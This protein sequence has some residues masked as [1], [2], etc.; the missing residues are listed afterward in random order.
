APGEC[1]VIPETI[2]YAGGNGGACH[3]QMYI[4]GTV[5]RHGSAA[6]KRQYLPKIAT[7]ALR[8]SAFGGPQPNS[9]AGTTKLQTTAIRK[10]D[11]YVVNGQKIFISRVLQSDLMLLLAR[12]TPVDHVKGRNEGVSGALVH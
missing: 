2:T 3:A 9:G 4:M 12:T 5:L 1:T 6:Q 10:G 7:G 8:L 11:R